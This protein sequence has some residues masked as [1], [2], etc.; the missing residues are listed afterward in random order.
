MY[1]LVMKVRGQPA[2]YRY[3][4]RTTKPLSDLLEARE[5]NHKENLIWTLFNKTGAL[6][7]SSDAAN[8]NLE[9]SG[10]G[11]IIFQARS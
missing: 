11:T 3:A 8:E 6:M 1:V 4:A 7:S 2:I 5:K 9:A 10:P